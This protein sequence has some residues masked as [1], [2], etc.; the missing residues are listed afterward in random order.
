MYPII[1][2]LVIFS[3]VFLLWFCFN[4]D[5]E[6]H[7]FPSKNETQDVQIEEHKHEEDETETDI[8]DV[9]LVELPIYSEIITE[10]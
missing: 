10:K 9:T 2:I 6:E 3:L 5:E 4:T 8:D 1:T 7:V